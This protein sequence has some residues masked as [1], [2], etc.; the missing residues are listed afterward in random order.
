MGDIEAGRL[1]LRKITSR[2]AKAIIAGEVPEGV[3]LADG[4][5]SQ[6]S[7]EVMDLLAGAREDE[8]DRFTPH[9]MVRCEDHA[10]IGEIG[11][12]HT[13]DD[14]ATVRIGYS[15]VEPSW[16][17]GYATDA[18]TALVAY[19]LCNPEIDHVVADTFPDHIASRRVMEKA[20]MLETGTRLD[21]E[22]GETVELVRYE[23][24]R[25]K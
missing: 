8:A 2:Q 12:H 11:W 10:V 22:D 16:G 1:V 23:A 18:V 9:F 3:A 5:P 4:Y 6:F 17:N 20:G 24:R 15:I 21:V 14:P 25:A 7:L 13:Q 19:L